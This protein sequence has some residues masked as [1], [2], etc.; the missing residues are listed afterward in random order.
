MMAKDF[1][2]NK[3]D[4]AQT[5]LLD[6]QQSTAVVKTRT[7]KHFSSGYRDIAAILNTER[8]SRLLSNFDNISYVIFQK[9]ARQLC[10]N[11]R[12]FNRYARCCQNTAF[13]LCTNHGELTDEMYCFRED[14]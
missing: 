14:K 7:C 3:T 2:V 12:K 5:H 10:Y 13:V 6:I 8:V 1:Y 11:V 4:K 9:T